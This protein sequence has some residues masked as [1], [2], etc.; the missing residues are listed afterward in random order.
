MFHIFPHVFE[1]SAPIHADLCFGQDSIASKAVARE[2]ISEERW[3]C[4]AV[5]CV[6]STFP[7]PAIQDN[8]GQSGE[9]YNEY[10]GF[11]KAMDGH[12]LSGRACRLARL[13]GNLRRQLE[14]AVEDGKL[15]RHSV[16]AVIPTSNDFNCIITT[17]NVYTVICLLDFMFGRF[18]VW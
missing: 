9:Q 2:F 3:M 12:R 7:F 1:C 14:E 15:A 6:I 17:Y 13:R 11:G 18:Y 4:W 5:A 8:K 10:L 16:I